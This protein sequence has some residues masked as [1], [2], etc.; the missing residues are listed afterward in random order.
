MIQSPEVT[1]L[2]N[3]DPMK[4]HGAVVLDGANIASQRILELN[5]MSASSISP[6]IKGQIFVTANVFGPKDRPQ[7]VCPDVT[8]L[9]PSKAH[10]PCPDAFCGTISTRAVVRVQ[11]FAAC[12][13]TSSAHGPKTPQR[14]RS[15]QDAPRPPTRSTTGTARRVQYIPCVP[16]E[17]L[18]CTHAAASVP[19]TRT[20]SSATMI[21]PV[22]TAYPPWPRRP[23]LSSSAAIGAPAWTL[24]VPG[25]PF[26]GRY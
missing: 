21:R 14:P 10:R 26:P 15:G 16:K 2:V 23:A 6:S 1:E 4:V 13:I 25:R 20:A 18:A 11:V 22:F 19:N 17:V 12:R 7:A 3:R 24:S 8:V 5:T 9:T